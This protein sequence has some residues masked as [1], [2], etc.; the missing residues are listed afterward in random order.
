MAKLARSKMK[1]SIG[2][3][4]EGKMKREHKIQ[5]S[6]VGLRDGYKV[7]VS[8][9]EQDQTRELIARTVP[10]RFEA[11]TIAKAF[12]SHYDVPWYKVEVSSG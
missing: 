3:I 12:A 8:I 5:A 10:S 2:A 1:P 6:I 9:T 11:E 7:T 4:R